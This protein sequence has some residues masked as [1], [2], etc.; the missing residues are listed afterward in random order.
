MHVTFSYLPYLSTLTYTDSVS[1]FGFLLVCGSFPLQ[2]V[3]IGES[4][5]RGIL[6]QTLGLQAPVHRFYPSLM[7]LLS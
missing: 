5:L 3:H 2:P 7:E 4:A 6:R 1:V